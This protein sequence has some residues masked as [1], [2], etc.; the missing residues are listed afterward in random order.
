LYAV[1]RYQPSG[2][3]A[4]YQD[5]RQVNVVMH[6][7]SGMDQQAA[8]KWLVDTVGVTPRV[9]TGKRRV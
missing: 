9:V 8:S 5:N 3:G 6:I 4:G 2:G 1:R 7:N